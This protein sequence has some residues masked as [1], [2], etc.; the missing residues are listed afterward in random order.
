MV[1]RHERESRID[2]LIDDR[3]IQSVGFC[4]G[5]PVPDPS[6]TQRID[7]DLQSGMPNDVEIDDVFQV[8]DIV[9]GKVL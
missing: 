7:T 3:E 1:D 2:L 6:A 8:I 5:L 9:S 4:N